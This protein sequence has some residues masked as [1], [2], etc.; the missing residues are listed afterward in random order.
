MFKAL[1]LIGLVIT[2]GM[3]GILKGSQL[4]QRIIMLYDIQNLVLTM[5][6]QMNYLKE[7]VSVLFEKLS[8]KQD[9]RAFRLPGECLLEMQ[10]KDGEMGEFW[11]R[12]AKE[13]YRKT[14]LT[15]EDIT[16]LSQMGKYLGQTDFAN[17][18][19]QFQ[20]TEE[21]LHRQI[22]EA[23]QQCAQKYSLYCRLGFLGGA[24]AALILI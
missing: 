9:S 20:W 16:I 2:S 23:E 15:E 6:S 18:Q 7:P 13:I 19:A 3:T 22:E 4:K 11:A 12:K 24:A 17:Q 1:G 14:A 8:K 10:S 21:R 5:K